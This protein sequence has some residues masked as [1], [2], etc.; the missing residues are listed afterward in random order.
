MN[1]AEPP[2]GTRQAAHQMVAGAGADAEGEHPRL[3]GMLLDERQHRIGVRDFAIRQH[4][5]LAR[6]IAVR[7]LLERR[8]C[9]A[10]RISVP[11]RSACMAAT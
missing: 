5:D 7:R 4:D 9:S 11:P 6:Q 1:S 2:T 8:I 10:G 3:R